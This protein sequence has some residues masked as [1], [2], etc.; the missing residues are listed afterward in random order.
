MSADKTAMCY[1]FDGARYDLDVNTMINTR[2][3]SSE[4][5]AAAVPMTRS[6]PIGD[7]A[8]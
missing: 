5:H 7:G 8:K 3:A 4:Q 6:T 1:C 2:A